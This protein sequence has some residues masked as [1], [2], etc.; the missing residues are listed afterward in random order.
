MLDRLAHFENVFKSPELLNVTP[1][2]DEDL[3]F[4]L[5]DM[6]QHEDQDIDN[7]TITGVKALYEKQNYVAPIVDE[8]LEAAISGMDILTQPSTFTRRNGKYRPLEL[9]NMPNFCRR[10]IG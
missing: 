2:V 5:N 4:V 1:H 9:L 6:A 3:V 7:R 10:A 8:E